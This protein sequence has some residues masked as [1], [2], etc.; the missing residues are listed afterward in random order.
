MNA[1]QIVESAIQALLDSHGDGWTLSAFVVV[2]GLEKVVPDNHGGDGHVQSTP[3]LYV[4]PNQPDWVTTG[5][6]IETDAMF[7]T[8]VE[9]D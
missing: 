9:E 7:S 4:P 6:M 2:C 3:W 5:L 1:Q 8:P